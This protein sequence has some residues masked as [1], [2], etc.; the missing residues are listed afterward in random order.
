MY[1]A[2]QAL[3]VSKMTYTV[4]SGTLNSAIPY[5]LIGIRFSCILTLN[6]AGA[7]YTRVQ[8]ILEILRYISFLSISVHCSVHEIR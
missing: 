4:L 1:I 3:P 7:A 2:A 6:F 8:L 5:L